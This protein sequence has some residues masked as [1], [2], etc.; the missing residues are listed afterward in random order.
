MNFTHAQHA[1]TCLRVGLLAALV[2][3]SPLFAATND[4]EAGL[5]HNERA[6]QDAI[7]QSPNGSLATARNDT[8]T[9]SLASNENAAQRAISGSN[10][11]HGAPIAAARGEP[12][13]A[14]NED[15]AQRVIVDLPRP[16]RAFRP[17]TSSATSMPT[18]SSQPIT[19]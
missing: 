2:L 13:L 16:R 12:E 5:A 11:T 19:P 18:T 1:V 6:A 4:G 9:T 14:Q 17:I 3:S 15:A 10:V 7:K 8:S